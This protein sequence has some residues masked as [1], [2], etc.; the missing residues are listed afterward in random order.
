MGSENSVARGVVMILVAGTA[1]GLA[2]N[3]VG[4]A[5]RPPRGLPWIAHNVSVP[6][7]ENLLPSDSTAAVAQTKASAGDPGSPGH[8]ETAE[9]SPA[10]G[11]APPAAPAVRA[12]APA[13]LVAEPAASGESA[14]P[15]QPPRATP[16]PAPLP[17]IPDVDQPV[18][19]KIGT[20]KLLFDAGAALFLDAR[21]TD[22]YEAGHIPGAM[23]LSES[24]AASQPESVKNLPVRGRPI[25]AY[26]QGGD[27]EA[28]L[29][30]ARNLVAS[31][32]RKV[33]VFT[34]G[35]PEWAAAGYPVEGG[36]G[37]P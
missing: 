31:G 2:H 11:G 19:V 6:E 4:F 36:R 26:C 32:Y 12:A 14:A 16:P 34:G 17:F 22:E 37:G 27:C 5:S 20:V 3:W 25:I 24:D 30:L 35:F 15:A 21:D 8:E 13:A 9:R 29:D 18:Q 1:L 7:L 10:T 28:S 23:R 33:L